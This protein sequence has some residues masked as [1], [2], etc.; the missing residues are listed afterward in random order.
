MIALTR[1]GI[2]VGWGMQFQAAGLP[3][4]HGG[5]AAR[6]SPAISGACS[7]C[8]CRRR[9]PVAAAR[10]ALGNVAAGAFATLLATP[11]SAPFL[12]TA[13]GFALAAGPVEIVG[14]FLALGVGFA[15]PYLAVAALPGLA[16][17]L[18]RPGRWMVA[19]AARPRPGARGDGARG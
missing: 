18:P 3:R 6:C 5:A 4:R 8:R 19:A 15:A 11:C 17:L 9:S 10:G 14:I 2:A 1:A 12:G 7:R 16:R 13:I